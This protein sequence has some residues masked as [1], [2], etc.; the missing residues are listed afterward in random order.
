MDFPFIRLV[1]FN[2]QT[3]SFMQCFFLTVEWERKT[4]IT[5]VPFG[6]TEVSIQFFEVFFEIFHAGVVPWALLFKG[7]P[8]SLIFMIRLTFSFSMILMKLVGQHGW[9]FEIR[10]EDHTK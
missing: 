8:K 6:R 3:M 9:I 10:A 5:G 7:C 2:H 4:G 1:F